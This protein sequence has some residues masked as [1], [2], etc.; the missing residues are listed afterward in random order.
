MLTIDTLQLKSQRARK[1][2]T[3]KSMANLLSITTS[4][5]TKKENGINP[6]THIELKSLKEIFELSNNE[7]CDIFFAN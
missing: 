5:Y 2:L 7:F 3:Q 6:F 4:S 1:G